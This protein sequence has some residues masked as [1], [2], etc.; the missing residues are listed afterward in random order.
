[1]AGKTL[2]KYPRTPLWPGS[3]SADR[4]DR[5]MQNP[6]NLLGTHITITEKLDGANLLLH[7]GKV[8]PRSTTSPADHRHPWTAMVRKHHAW[9]LSQPELQHVILYA[10][11]LYAIH[12]IEY[13]QMP[14]DQTTRVFASQSNGPDTFDHFELTRELAE[15]LGM[16]TV[17]VIYRG[18]ASSLEEIQ[19]ILDEAHAGRSALGATIEG[20]V[21]RT[22]GS[23]RR[24]DFSSHLCKSVRRNHVTTAEHWKTH[25][26][27][28]RTTPAS[29][30][31]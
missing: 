12:S 26:N 30:H 5:L 15:S 29:T 20:A 17:P 8:F 11:D 10:E 25:W 6:E 7:Q 28:C 23:F 21:I 4:D 16:P 3:P 14:E 9:K 27:P 19:Q 31:T 24:N 22:T 18:V 13:D 1:M 2:P